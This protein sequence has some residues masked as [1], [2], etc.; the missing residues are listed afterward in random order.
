ME[1]QF[2]S[3]PVPLCS[4]ELYLVR[5]SSSCSVQPRENHLQ[6]SNIEDGVYRQLDIA[7][8]VL[9]VDLADT[10]FTVPLGT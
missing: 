1:L 10:R 6:P 2:T 4:E 7:C 5:A 8:K 9:N 3:N